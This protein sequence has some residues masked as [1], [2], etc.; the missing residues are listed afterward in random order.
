[1]LWFFKIQNTRDVKRS[2]GCSNHAL[3]QAEP[4]ATRKHKNIKTPPKQI[5]LTHWSGDFTCPILSRCG[6]LNPPQQTTRKIRQLN[7]KK[8]CGQSIHTQKRVH[9]NGEPTT[10]KFARRCSYLKVVDCRSKDTSIFLK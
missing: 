10:Y 7:K 9:K 3:P 4:V 5:R 8:E 1:M 2:L 6:N